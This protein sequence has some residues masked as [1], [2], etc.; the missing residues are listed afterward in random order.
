VS[1]VGGVQ[2]IGIGNRIGPGNRHIDRSANALVRPCDDLGSGLALQH[3]AVGG[4]DLGSTRR[5]IGVVGSGLKHLGRIRL[6]E[7]VSEA[8]IAGAVLEPALAQIAG[9]VGAEQPLGFLRAVGRSWR[10]ARI[11]ARL[12]P[13]VSVTRGA[14]SSHVPW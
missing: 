10:S 9:I 5:S 13:F 11:C 4:E 8:E 7:E 3:L 1:V 2:R 14:Y 6:A 12:M